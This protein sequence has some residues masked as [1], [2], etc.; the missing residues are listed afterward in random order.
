MSLL[1]LENIC[2]RYGDMKAVDNVSLEVQS[3]A[4]TSLV[5]SNGAGKSTILNA[6]SGLVPLREGSICF[7]EQRI[8]KLLSH[9]RVELGLIQIPEGRQVFPFMT[10][11]ENLELGSMLK[12][13]KPMRKENLD[14]VMGIFPILSERR[15]QIAK[16]LSGGEQQMLAIARGLMGNPKLLM[17]DEPSLGLAPTL[18][19]EIFLIISNINKMGITALLVEQDVKASLGLATWGY[20]LENGR[21]VLSGKAKDIL[22]DD[23]IRKIY[24][25]L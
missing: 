13:S 9:E 18:V 21:M 17:F 16:T 22:N 10:T 4:I 23:S 24:L 20:V 8:E 7:E 1:R 2:V 25:G 5:G 15:N 19:K 14:K 6:I 3:G 11:K 12:K